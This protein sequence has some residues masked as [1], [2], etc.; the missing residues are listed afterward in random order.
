MLEKVPTILL[1]AL[2]GALGAVARYLISTL[3]L[4]SKPLPWGTL[5]VNVAGSFLLGFFVAMFRLGLLDSPT[6]V[7]VGV[8]F[9]GSFTTMSSFAV[10]T[11]SLSDES[12]ELALLNIVIM[13]VMVLVGAFIGRA[14][15]LFLFKV[16][17]P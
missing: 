1:V 11:I 16:G 2:G 9:M 17:E 10:E 14:S 15:A 12:L 8:G 7:F 5:V 3:F 6:I 4:E 13:I